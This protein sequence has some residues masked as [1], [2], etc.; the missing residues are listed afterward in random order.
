MA[1]RRAEESSIAA[2]VET[3]EQE[4][5]KK[6]IGRAGEAATIEGIHY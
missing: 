3:S 5:G 1:C 4:R 2:L 6:Y